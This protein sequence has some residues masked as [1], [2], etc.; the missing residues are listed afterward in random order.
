MGGDLNCVIQQSV[1]RQPASKTLQRR[2]SSMLKYQSLEI[3][4]LDIWRSKFPK[5]RDFLYYSSRHT[6]CSRTDYFFTSKTS[7]V[8]DW[9]PVKGCTPPPAHRLLEIGTR[10]L[11][12]DATY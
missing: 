2:M 6:S 11:I 9:Q 8:M 1:D 5:G 12:P 4:L 3:G 7:P 10:L